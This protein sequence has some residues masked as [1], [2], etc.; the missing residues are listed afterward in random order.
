MDSDIA[1]TGA[2]AIFVAGLALAGLVLVHQA[3]YLDRHGKI[4]IATGNSHY[5]QLASR[6]Q[7]EL[8]NYGVEVEIKRSTEGFAALKSLT[9]DSSGVTAGFVKGGLVGS[10][11][12]RLATEKAK[13]RH[14]E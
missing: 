8:K 13:G 12:G 5:F 2:I 6:Y 14:I 3:Q 9:D 4:V 11:R 10:L 1:K 7:E